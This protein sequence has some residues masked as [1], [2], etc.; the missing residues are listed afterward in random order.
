ME[1]LVAIILFPLIALQPQNAGIVGCWKTVDDGTG[2]AESIIEILE[3]PDGKYYGRISKMLVK[4]V[5]DTCDK[6]RD[7]RKGR[8]LLGLEV[9]RGLAKEKNGQVYGGGTITDPKNGKTYKC[10]V[11]RDGDRL[12]VR[13]Y[14]GFSLMGRTQTWHLVKQQ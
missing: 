14:V 8:P 13:G 12:H 11:T 4:P 10:T 2:E 7:D 5:N 3:K 9:I 6:C 1:T